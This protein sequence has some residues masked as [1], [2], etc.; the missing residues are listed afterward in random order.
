MSVAAAGLVAASVPLLA[1]VV[2]A[3]DHLDAPKTQANQAA[4]ITD[5]Y[6][7]HTDQGK[8]VV[9]VNFAGLGE[10]GAEPKYNSTIVYGVHIDNDGDNKADI[11]TWV[12]F[13]QNSQGEWGV[14]VTDLPGGDPVI[15]GPVGTTIDTKLGLRV[16]AGLRD[17]P[18]F[19]DLDGFQKTLMTGTVSFNKDNDTFAKT[20]VSSIILEMSTDAVK[21]AGNSFTVWASTRGPA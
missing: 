12:R 6:A 17:D 3:A 18:F 20:N 1:A 11:D 8:V 21:G 13:G 15:T 9:A 5:L 10:A 19:F 14:Q 4:D 16:Y 2:S 7:W